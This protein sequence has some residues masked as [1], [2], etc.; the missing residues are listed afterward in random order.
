MEKIRKFFREHPSIIVNAVIG[1]I[2]FIYLEQ[3]KSR[4]EPYNTI[5]YVIAVI[6]F[7]SIAVATYTSLVSKDRTDNVAN[8]PVRKTVMVLFYAFLT[9]IY[10]SFIMFFPLLVLSGIARLFGHK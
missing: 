7:L 1:A 3:T 4:M 9:T 8:D 2:V 5:P 6:A 10:S